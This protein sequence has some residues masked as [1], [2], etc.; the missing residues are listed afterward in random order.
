MT[1]L[2]VPFTIHFSLELPDYEHRRDTE[3]LNFA[4]NLRVPIAC[5][6]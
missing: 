4:D 6:R 1:P 3:T 5:L 2:T